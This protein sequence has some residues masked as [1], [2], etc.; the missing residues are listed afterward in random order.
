MTVE[1]DWAEIRRLHTAEGMAIKAIVRKMGISRNAV[2]RALASDS[3][4]TYERSPKGSVVDAVEPQIRE[5]LRATPTMPAT[6]IAERIDWPHGLT[7]LKAVDA[8]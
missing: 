5:L 4:P 3:P 2:R 1:E 7:V 8:A 6:V